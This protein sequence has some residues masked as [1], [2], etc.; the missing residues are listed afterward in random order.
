MRNDM[1]RIWAILL[2]G[3]LLLV[4]VFAGGRRDTPK[5]TE[6]VTLNILMS[7]GWFE[8]VCNALKPRMEQKGILLNVEAVDWGTYDTRQR[9]AM[10]E[11]GGAYDVMFLPGNM[12]PL[13]AGAKG[14]ISIDSLNRRINPDDNDIYDSVKTFAV[15]NGEYYVVPF[16]APSMVFYYRT[17]IYEQAG[18]QPPK[19]ID[20]MY[21]TA[22]MLTKDGMYGIAYPGGPGEGACSFWS[23]F[24]WSYG[25]TYFD[26]DWVPQLNTP[27][28]IDSAKMFAT[29][30]Q[31]CAPRGVTT[32]QNEETVAAFSAGNVAAMIMWPGFY[33]RVTD[34][35]QSRVFDKVGV[36]PV[37]IGPAGFAAPRFG[38]WGMGI[39]AN[40]AAKIDAASELISAFCGQDGL[41]EFVVNYAPTSSKRVNSSPDFASNPTI[42]AV[43]AVLDTAQ[44]RPAIPES[45][46]YITAVGNAI[47]SIVA[48][49]PVTATMNRLQ[50]RVYDIMKEAGYYK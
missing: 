4:P 23:Y 33:N 15:V 28:A 17:D 41:R 26:D 27:E 47:N 9:L 1:K 22:K 29:M 44:E 31:E 21:K 42:A 6:M 24:L 36:A 25:G 3:V 16:Q 38:T 45:S 2:L 8:D 37:P 18:L 12:V 14:L 48:G 50:G 7:T 10:T 5:D 20:E 11:G 49:S 30:L 13:W 43:G 46:Q 32:W 34:E 35:R 39:T 19:T 40:G